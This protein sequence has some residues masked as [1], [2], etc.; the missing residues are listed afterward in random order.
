MA[1]TYIAALYELLQRDWHRH[2][3]NLLQAD[4]KYQ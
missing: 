2:W 4:L 1:Q 3:A